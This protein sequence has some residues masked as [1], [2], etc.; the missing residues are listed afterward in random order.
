MGK[1]GV[2]TDSHSGITRE[3]AKALGVRVVPMPFYIGD[4]CF[5]E[6]V[7][8]SRKE[9]FTRL[10]A[11]EK[12]STSQPSPESVMRVWDEA[13]QEYEQI[14]YI[15]ISSGL[16]G[17]CMTA[18]ALANDEPYEGRVFVV[19]NGRVSTLLHRSILDAFDLIAKGFSAEEVR[20]KLE[21]YRA[22]MVIYVGVTTLE[23]LKRG[24]RI[25]SSKALVG[26][27]LN[28]KPILRFDVGTLDVFQNCR[29]TAKMRR[30]MIEAMRHELENRFKKWHDRG[31]VYLLAASSSVKEVTESWIH[32]IEEAFP[33]M[34]VM[35]DDLSLGLC[36]HI[37]PGGLGI[38][39]SIM[40]H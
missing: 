31:E 3:E 2:V 35:C 32:E 14:L 20:D 12:V 34:K 11:G 37:G 8:L 19:D 7:N 15:P 29:G 28:I 23:Y 36:C 5:F 21:K 22:R 17:S 9:F 39:C 26:S 33:G 6:N 40:P 13:L 24:G 4:Q 25:N 30:A 38:G 18:Q 27:L 10:E 1:I 16:S